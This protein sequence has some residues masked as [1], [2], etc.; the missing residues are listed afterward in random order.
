M[1]AYSNNKICNSSCRVI[2]FSRF[3]DLINKHG[4]SMH[5]SLYIVVRGLRLFSLVTFFNMYN[6]QIEI[7]HKA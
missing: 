6:L 1:V 3:V 2:H 7:F 4:T 5:T